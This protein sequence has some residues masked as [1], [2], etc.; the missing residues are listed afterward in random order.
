[1]KKSAVAVLL[2]ASMAL[3]MTACGGSSDETTAAA[4]EATE[5]ATTAAEAETTTAAESDAESSE[6]E[7]KAEAKG[8]PVKDPSE[9]KVGMV[10]DVGG[11]N[12]GS[13]NQSSWEGLQRAGEELGIQVNYL[14]SKNDA[15]YTPNIENFVDEDYDLIISVGYMLSDATR[16]AAEAYPDQQFAIIDDAANS[17]LPNVTCLMFEQAQSSYLV[18]YVAG[19][20]TESNKVGFVIG[21]ASDSMHQFG[22]GYLAG[23]KDANPDAEIL[24]YNANAFNDPATGKSATT[25]MV[26]DG[27][28]VVFHAA[29]GTGLGVIEGCKENG[30]WAI[31]VD[32]DQSSIAPETILTSAMKRVDNASFDVAEAALY[33]TLEGGVK[34]YDITTAGVDIAPTTDNLTPELLSEIEDVK[35]KIASG[36][37]VVPNNKADF[38]AAYG[39]IYTLDD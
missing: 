23:V 29:G 12:D 34:T 13:F 8:T 24:Q 31:G 16:K 19:K 25:K 14:E 37:I 28:D 6:A 21:M 18:G 2:A 3:S 33:G 30:I 15:D 9:F 26:T 1:M 38:E 10:T 20:V 17:D 27:A 36:E 35:A 32:S 7:T 11:V 5:A 4:T 39:D 22:Y